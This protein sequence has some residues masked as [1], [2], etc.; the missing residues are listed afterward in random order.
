MNID[1]KELEAQLERVP[2]PAQ[3]DPPIGEPPDWMNDG[4]PPEE[5]RGRGKANGKTP[6][7]ETPPAPRRPPINWPSL[8]DREPPPREWIVAHWIP[9]GH[10]TLLAGRGGIGKTLLA[11]HIASALALG[12]EYLEPLEPRKVLMWAGE[13]DEAEMWRRQR[14]I[15]SW[16]G[17]P[18][19]ALHERFYLH[20][21]AGAD[22]TLM[23]PIYG[24]LMPTPM[25]AELREQVLDYRA[26]VVILDN[27][28]RLFGGSENDRHA[29]TTFC[30]LVQGACA[31]AA[32]LLLG[33][34]AKATGSEYSGSTAW[35]GA[36]RARLYLGDRPPDQD[37]TDDDAPI[38]DDVRYLARRKAN[39]SPLDLRR[40]RMI[41]GVLIPD[42]IDPVRQDQ[43]RGELAKDVVRRA[44]RVLAER[45]IY[46]TASTASSSYLPRLAKQYRLL[47]TL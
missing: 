46:G 2:M 4:P 35:E 25:L 26:E 24:E 42:A 34:P 40:C 14:D 21:Y 37:A 28:A 16:M 17:Q 18:L 20:S 9:A 29:V 5:P 19:S 1:A 7:P 44:V 43:P 3:D 39:Y 12:H 38:A 41:G 36:V 6:P 45:S 8:E 47:E 33:H 32:V 10:T 27:V 31:P 11:Q 30:A 22:I 23:A 15:S 13:D